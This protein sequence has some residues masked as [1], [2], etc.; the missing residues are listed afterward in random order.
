MYDSDRPLEFPEDS[1]LQLYFDHFIKYHKKGRWNRRLTY[2]GGCPQVN[3]RDTGRPAALPRAGRLPD[4]RPPRRR[5]LAVALPGEDGR[6]QRDRLRRQDGLRPRPRGPGPAPH[7]LPRRAVVRRA[8]AADG[9]PS[10]AASSAS[11]R[12]RSA[13]TCGSDSCSRPPATCTRRSAGSWKATGVKAE[14]YPDL[15]KPFRRPFGRDYKTIT[16]HGILTDWRDQLAYFLDDEQ[17][18]PGLPDG[19]AG[20]RRGRRRRGRRRRGRRSRRSTGMVA[21]AGSTSGRSRSGL[22]VVEGWFRA[23]CPDWQGLRSDEAGKR[24]RQNTAP[25]VLL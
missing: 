8:E 22:T 16:P 18:D 14:V 3:R 17:A 25:W 15:S 5:P 19:R 21:L 1:Q 9:A 11:P 4:P 24:R 2:A 12:P 23:G 13:S 10:R 7:L 20:L 6:P